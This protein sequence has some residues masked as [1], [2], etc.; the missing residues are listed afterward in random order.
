MPYFYNGKHYTLAGAHANGVF[1]GRTLRRDGSEASRFKL[2]MDPKD[3][4]ALPTRIE[5]HARSFLRL[6]LETMPHNDATAL[7]PVLDRT[8]WNTPA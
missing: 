4:T 7:P 5:F 1:E 3:S 2:W 8:A 6:T